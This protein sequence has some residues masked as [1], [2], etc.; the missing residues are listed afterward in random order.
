MFLSSY[1]PFVGTVIDGGEPDPA[2]MMSQ[3]GVFLGIALLA[4]PVFLII[5]AMLEASACAGTSARKAFPSDSAAMNGVLLA[6]ICSGSYSAFS[7]T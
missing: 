4:A 7:P 3:I 6:F 2:Q 5:Y 1:L